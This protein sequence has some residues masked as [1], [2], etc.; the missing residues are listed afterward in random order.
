MNDKVLAV[1]RIAVRERASQSVFTLIAHVIGI[2]ER[3]GQVAAEEVERTT[4]ESGKVAVDVAAG[5][6][7]RAIASK[8]A[9][10]DAAAGDVGCAAA[11]SE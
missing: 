11:F 9:G 10:A 5:D 1:K 8:Q 2:N 3:I 4:V 6:I 7:D